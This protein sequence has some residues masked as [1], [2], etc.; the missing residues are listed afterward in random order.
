MQKVS[1]IY[2]FCYLLL[3]SNFDFVANV[4][5][6]WALPERSN[7]HPE[8][9]QKNISH[10]F[11]IESSKL[12][13]EVITLR[14]IQ[15]GEEI[16]LDYGDEWEQ[17]WQEHLLN[18]KPVK[19]AEEYIS[20]HQM[21]HQKFEKNLKTEFEQLTDPYPP[22]TVTVFNRMFENRAWEG[23]FQQGLNLT[24]FYKKKLN[25]IVRCEILSYRKVKGHMLYTAAILIPDDEGEDETVLI[26]DMPRE[27][28]SFEDR[29]YTSDLF[30]DNA[31]RHDIRIPDDM[32]PDAWKNV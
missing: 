24:T 10:F 9:L 6:Q 22:N 3:S 16:F 11:E 18:W 23:A 21:N 2:I 32:F 28:F 1:Y 26:E 20:A 8:L 15:P 27:A 31:F 14:D 29:S 12:A 13:M 17:S 30:L 4:K 19:K 5:L 7:H 25:E